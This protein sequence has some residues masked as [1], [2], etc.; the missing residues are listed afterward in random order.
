MFKH[1]KGVRVHVPA[2]SANLGPGFDVLGLALGLYNN[3]TVSPSNRLQIETVGFGDEV[4]C[5]ETN[6]FY[7]AFAFLVQRMVPSIAMPPV[8]IKMELAIPQGKGLGSS[9]TAVVGGLVAATAMLGS[10]LDKRA[11]LPHAVDLE[12]GGHADNVAPALLGNLVVNAY[13]STGDMRIALVVP[14][15]DDLRAVLLI[16]DFAMD[17]VQGRELM[18]S[19]YT[20]QDVVY[21]TSRVALLLSALQT[22]RYDLLS[23]AM[24]DA[25]HQPYRA[26]LFAAMPDLIR[27]A[28]DGGAHGACLSGGGSAI[29][30]LAEPGI[31]GQVGHAMLEAAH[32]AGLVGE[33][34][35][36]D[37][38]REGARVELL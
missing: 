13:D 23:T 9:A 38:D 34:R 37:V 1:L 27:A 14:F 8:Y 7:R 16:P 22:H 28:L 24:Q 25:L 6:L 35:V 29:L 19:H 31:A 15:P 33:V 30:A 32:A 4:P 2:T 18:P 5:D 12:H 36:L 11:L 26:K 10:P 17:T 21:N 20:R 3:F